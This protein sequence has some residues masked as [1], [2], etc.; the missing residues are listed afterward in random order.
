MAAFHIWF[1][2]SFGR[3]DTLL[4]SCIMRLLDSH[5]VSSK[6]NDNQSKKYLHP[7][8][9]D[10]QLCNFLLALLSFLHFSVHLSFRHRIIA[11]LSILLLFCLDCVFSHMQYDTLHVYIQT[12]KTQLRMPIELIFEQRWHSTQ[13]SMMP[14]SQQPSPAM[15][16]FLDFNHLVLIPCFQTL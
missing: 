12:T 13:K 10:D 4:S 2:Q 16:H 15:A 8:T 3:Q 1:L 7:T 5:E 6:I 9:L 14:T 11:N